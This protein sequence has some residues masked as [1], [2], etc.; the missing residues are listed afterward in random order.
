M[1]ATLTSEAI[2]F[3]IHS[4]I[5]LGGTFQKA[6]AGKEGAD[7]ASAKADASAVRPPGP[8]TDPPVMPPGPPPS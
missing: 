8:A 2:I 3:A 7:E 5:K 4:A 6:Y 1:T